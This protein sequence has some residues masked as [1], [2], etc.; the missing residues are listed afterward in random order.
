VTWLTR[1]PPRRGGVGTG[2]ARRLSASRHE[3]ETCRWPSV[4]TRV[5]PEGRRSSLRVKVWA[6]IRAAG[7][8]TSDGSEAFDQG[9]KGETK[10]AQYLK[11]SADWPGKSP[12]EAQERLCG[13]PGHRLG[14][15]GRPQAQYRSFDA[16]TW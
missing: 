1:R 4:F 12:A 3:V 15:S 14:Q 8:L 10:R 16:A 2:A 5:A 11:P 6:N 13:V 9:M 7:I